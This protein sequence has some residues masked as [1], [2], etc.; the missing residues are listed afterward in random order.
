MKTK[1]RPLQPTAYFE[2]TYQGFSIY[3]FSNGKRIYIG[4]LPSISAVERYALQRGL[5]LVD[6]DATRQPVQEKLK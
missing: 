6:L 2:S 4:K 5:R 1:P 3:A